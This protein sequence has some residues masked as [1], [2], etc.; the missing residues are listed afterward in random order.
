MDKQERKDQSTGAS[1]AGSTGTMKPVGR[2][3]A[4]T[5]TGNSGL[6]ARKESTKNDRS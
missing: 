3:P 5:G 6:G 2:T 1:N 4:P